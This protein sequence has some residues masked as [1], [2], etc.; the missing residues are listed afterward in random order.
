[1]KKHEY[2]EIY[3]SEVAARKISKH[4][5]RMLADRPRVYRKTLLRYRKLAQLLLDCASKIIKMLQSELLLSSGDTE[6]QEL[7][8]DYDVEQIEELRSSVES[9]DNFVKPTTT[10]IG[11]LGADA[12]RSYKDK[13]KQASEF[14]FGYVEVNECAE[15]LNTWISKRF[16]GDNPNFRFQ[17][18][19]IPNWAAFIVIA[20][21]KNHASGNAKNF[22][23]QFYAWC[24]SLENIDNTWALPTTVYRMTQHINPNDLTMDAVVIYDIL[25]NE[26]LYQLVGNKVKLPMNSGYIVDLVKEYRPDLKSAVRTRIS[27]QSQLLDELHFIPSNTLSEVDKI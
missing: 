1:M 16:S 7:V 20:Y 4:L 23:N 22:M 14:D 5:D 15:I 2:L 13:F 9:L 10:S 26:C 19:E 12:V 3:P 11:K 25:M 24:D 6:F 27:R 21:G 17:P 18:K 8:S